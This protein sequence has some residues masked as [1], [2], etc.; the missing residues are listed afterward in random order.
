MIEKDKRK[1]KNEREKQRKQ[2]RRGRCGE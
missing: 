2:E 1:V